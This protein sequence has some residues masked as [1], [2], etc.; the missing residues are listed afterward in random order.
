MNILFLATNYPYPPDS[1]HNLRTFNILKGLAEYHKVFFVGFNKHGRA[2]NVNDTIAKICASVN[3][4]MAPEDIS[5]GSLFGSLTRNL[6]SSYPFV[7]EKYYRKEIRDRIKIIMSVNSID[8]VHCD[9]LHMARYLEDISYVPNLLTEHNIESNRLRTLVYNSKN[10]FFKLYMYLQYKK[11]F[12]FEQRMINEFD[13]VVAISP[14]DI[15]GLKV[16]APKANLTC[17]PNGVDTDFFKPAPVLPESKS[18]IWT[19]GMRDMY[20]KEAMNYFCSRIF[21]NIYSKIKGLKFVVIGDSPTP[22][23]IEL[24]RRYEGVEIRG[25][26]DD[27]RPFIESSM[28]FVAP[29]KSGGGTK[30][31]VLNAMSMGKAVVTTKIGAE[32]IDVINGQHLVIADDPDSFARNIVELLN[33]SNNIKRLGENARRLIIE[34]YDWRIISRQANEIYDQLICKHAE[35]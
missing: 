9:I 29:L 33:S 13:L 25:Y 14:E 20:N 10:P 26:V 31:K 1:G 4:F 28:V 22:S 18:I 16:M 34:K 24:A 17:L 3:V 11:L 12:L 23:V 5:R 30:L 6:F 15:N 8:L 19:G 7:A 27:I 32:G 35:V 2:V 21:P